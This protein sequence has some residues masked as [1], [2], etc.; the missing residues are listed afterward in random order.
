MGELYAYILVGKP[1][2][3]RLA[4]CGLNVSGLGVCYDH[5]NELSG[6]IKEG[7]S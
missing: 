1:G 7:I 3:K 6:S 2:R 5:S 4:S